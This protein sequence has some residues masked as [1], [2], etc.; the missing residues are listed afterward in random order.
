VGRD[1]AALRSWAADR[2]LPA[3]R[4]AQVHHGLYR[5][6]ATSP[7]ELTDLPR[8][9]REQLDLEV[10]L[11]DLRV[12]HEVSDSSGQT[13]KTLF[14]LQDGALVESVLM[15][16]GGRDIRR[17]H[18]VCLSSQVGCALACTFCATGR[19]GWARDLTVGEMVEQIL[20]F[21]RLLRTRGEQVTNIV[22]MGMGE[23]FL[24]YD[25]VLESVRLLTDPDAFGLGARHITISTSGV[26]PA[27]QRFARENLQVGLAVSLHAPDDALRSTL[28]PLNRRYPLAEVLDAC[29]EYIARTHRRVSFEYTMLEGVNDGV[30][31]AEGL[32]RLLRGMLCHIN[33]I[34]W[35]RVDDM[36]YHPS[37][38]LVISD[39]RDRLVEYGLAA[40]IRDTRGS[41]ISA[42][43]GQLRTTTMRDRKSARPLPV[44]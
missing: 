26:V 23:P 20:Y 24:N 22:Y 36:P 7:G 43:C 8:A 10:R 16:Y 41:G 13:T 15:A 14:A 34:P 5:R 39:F 35:N 2:N 1:L 27:I 12:V 21:A 29:E 3:F 38:P 6:L 44:V 33:L 40:T 42:A 37:S 11:S 9:L 19:Q 17:R 32:A 28:V 30:E 31:Q 18:T 4:A 25:A